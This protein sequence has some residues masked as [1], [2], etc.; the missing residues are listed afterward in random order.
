LS[1]AA[2]AR[3]REDFETAQTLYRDAMSASSDRKLQA[4]CLRSQAHLAKRQGDEEGYSKKFEA[5]I[6]LL[7]EEL[8][9]TRNE[10]AR[11]RIHFELGCDLGEIGKTEEAL[12]HA[13]KAREGFEKAGD[14]RGAA[15]A[16]FEMAR[17]LDRLERKDDARKI[18]LEVQQMIEGKPFYD[19]AAELALIFANFDFHSRNFADASRHIEASLALCKE[20]DLPMSEAPPI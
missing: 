11:T 18:Y 1:L 15:N 19:V 10:I 4:K 12:N 8:S 9:A 20:H 6:A 13:R 3:E 5:A 7:R 16:A 2:L 14:V 17:S